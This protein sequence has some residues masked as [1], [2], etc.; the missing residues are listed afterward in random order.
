MCEY[1][2]IA[3]GKSTTQ[4]RAIADHIEET[5]EKGRG[6]IRPGHTEGGKE[7]LWI[8]LD[9]G[10]V[11]AHIFHNETRRFYNL[12]RLWGDAPQRRSRQ[13]RKKVRSK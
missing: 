2:I 4:V 11:V 1:F 12:E 8:L 13:I 10:D 6:H 3:S 7:A 9:Y 5:L